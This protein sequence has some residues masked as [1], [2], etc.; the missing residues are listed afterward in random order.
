MT[1]EF[2]PLS[3]SLSRRIQHVLNKDLIS[4]RRIIHQHISHRAYQFPVLNDLTAGH[5]WLLLWTIFL[6]KDIL[7]FEIRVNRGKGGA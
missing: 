1:G 7:I 6:L 2:L 5:E 3:N 4:P